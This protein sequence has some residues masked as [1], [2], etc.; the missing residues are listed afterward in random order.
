LASQSSRAYRSRRSNRSLNSIYQINAIKSLADY[1]RYLPIPDLAACLPP[2]GPPLTGPWN[3]QQPPSFLLYMANNTRLSNGHYFS[4]RQLT[5][6]LNPRAVVGL[7]P[8]NDFVVAR[9]VR[10]Y[11]HK[12]VMLHVFARMGSLA[13]I[14]LLL[15]PPMS[16]L[17]ALLLSGLLTAGFLAAAPSLRT[18]SPSPHLT[19]DPPYFA[20]NSLARLVKG[21]SSH[22][23]SDCCYH[24]AGPISRASRPALTF[25]LS[26]LQP[27]TSTSLALVKYH[28]FASLPRPVSP[29]LSRTR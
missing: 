4:Q 17:L 2:Y 16:A 20:L 10:L 1:L 14:V 19:S 3:C 9:G 27:P 5:S 13:G 25:L 28:C 29:L 24:S 12:C 7:H 6:N 11:I 18:A 23:V 8:E 22:A 21:K 15:T 26:F